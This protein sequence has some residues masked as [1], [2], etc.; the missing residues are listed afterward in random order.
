MRG[1]FSS[2]GSRISN[3]SFGAVG[4][5]GRW[6]F[7][8]FTF[9]GDLVL[10]ECTRDECSSTDSS[11]LASSFFRAN[12]RVFGFLNPMRVRSLQGLAGGGGSDRRKWGL[13]FGS[14]EGGG[15]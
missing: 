11:S 12:K 5:P 3:V 15:G 1:S 14:S 2:G 8:L 10:A 9:R 7:P 6:Y 4:R 13:E